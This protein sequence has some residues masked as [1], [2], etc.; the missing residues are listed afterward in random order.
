MKSCKKIVVTKFYYEFNVRVCKAETDM[1]PEDGEVEK[2]GKNDKTG[3][4]MYT[5]WKLAEIKYTLEEVEYGHI[6]T[7]FGSIPKKRWLIYSVIF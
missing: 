3:W 4:Q 1:I 6:G 7:E 5:S 2:R